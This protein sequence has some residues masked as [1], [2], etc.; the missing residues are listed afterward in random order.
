MA[1]NFNWVEEQKTTT[2]SA[3][4]PASASAP[5]AEIEGGKYLRINQGRRPR[6]GGLL[7]ELR[8]GL[9][10]AELN[11]IQPNWT[12]QNRTDRERKEF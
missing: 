8:L 6:G 7:A 9:S 5:E 3:P 12:E 2:A 11:W 1:I 4:A 10:L